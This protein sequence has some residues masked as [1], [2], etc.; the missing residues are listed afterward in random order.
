MCP[1][2]KE[3]LNSQYRD[4]LYKLE[5]H[6]IIPVVSGGTNVLKNMTLL[7]KTCHRDRAALENSNVKMD[8]PYEG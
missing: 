8:E 1:I 6:H 7:H 2:C 3:S 5:I 4:V